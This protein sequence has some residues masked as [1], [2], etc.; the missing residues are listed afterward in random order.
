MLL[1]LDRAVRDMDAA[2][3]RATTAVRLKEIS[4]VVLYSP[5]AHARVKLA[6]A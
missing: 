4:A 3:I 6:K 1:S 5:M 2:G